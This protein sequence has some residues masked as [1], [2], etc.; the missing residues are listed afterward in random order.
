MMSSS[1]S[2]PALARRSWI[3]RK[4]TRLNSSHVE[5]S[6]AVFCLKKKNKREQDEQERQVEPAEEGGVP[7]GEGGEQ[8]RTGDYDT[9]RVEVPHGSDRVEYLRPAGVVLD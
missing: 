4:S 7:L 8:A 9:R 6:Y 3:D 2:A 5:I 1:W